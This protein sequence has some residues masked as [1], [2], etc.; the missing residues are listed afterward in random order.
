MYSFAQRT[1]TQVIDEPWYGYYLSH[2]GVNH[3]GRD[4]VLKHMETDPEKILDN[5]LALKN[6]VPLIF[7]KN[8]SHHFQDLEISV[9]KEF[10]NVFLIRDPAEMLAS[11]NV[12]LPSPVLRDTGL[13]NQWKL[14]NELMKTGKEPPVLDAEFLL[15]DPRGI[16]GK[17]CARLGIPFMEKML[18]WKKGPRPEDGIW[19][20]YWYQKVHE[21]TGFIPYIKKSGPFPEKLKMLLGECKPYYENLRRYA[22]R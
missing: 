8:M 4:E 6:H 5:L 13:D 1:D 11:L 15:N 16:L 20:K 17:L 12:Q 21:S 7:I 9:L 3:P 2:T 19:A 22:I 18:T 10:K 14:F